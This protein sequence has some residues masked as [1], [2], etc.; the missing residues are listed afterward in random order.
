M[1]SFFALLSVVFVFGIA[2][3]QTNRQPAPVLFGEGVLSV[4]EVYRGSFAPDG[5][6]FYFFKKVT[7][8]QEDYRIFVSRLVNGAWTRPERVV[9]GGDFSDLYPSISKDGK[10][11][12]FSSYRPAPGD[13][14]PKPN[15]H[16]WYVD[17]QGDGWG[18]PVFLAAA[19]KLDHYHSWV[20]FAGDGAIHF[21]RTTPDWRLNE[22]LV[23]SWNGKE[24]SSPVTFEASERWKSWSKDVR[25]VGGSP[26]PDGK[27]IFLDV[28]TRNPKTGRGASDIWVSF[29]NGK[30]W[31][32]P[33][34]LG[35]SVNSD[36]FDVFPFFSPDGKDL[37][38]VR[39]FAAF[40]RVSLKEALKSAR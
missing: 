2:T 39:D 33:K 17:R 11:M 37:Y 8:N 19:N 25:I 7:P 22:T 27:V 21:R 13:T 5:R 6:S 18:E 32:E 24:Y 35:A 26:S 20:E 23:T 15:A 40:Y 3:A 36:G 14:S 10:R 4:G 28:A 38:F 12:A 34:A 31:T 30:D 9:L 16:L 1:K 29:R